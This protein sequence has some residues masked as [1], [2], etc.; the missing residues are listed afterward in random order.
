LLTICGRRAGC[1]FWPLRSVG[2]R[3]NWAEE[4]RA[5]REHVLDSQPLAAIHFA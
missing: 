2:A 3:M 4:R 5:G 1:G